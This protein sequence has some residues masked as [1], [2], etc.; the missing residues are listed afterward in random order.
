MKK[1]LIIDDDPGVRESYDQI[2]S[3]NPISDIM[4]RGRDLFAEEAQIPGAMSEPQY[5]ITLADCGEVGVGAVTEAVKSQS[6]YAAA[7]I[8][9]MM[10]GIDGAE[11]ARQ[12][13]HIDPAIKIVIV[14]AY[15]DYTPDDIVRLVGR[16]DIFYLRKPFNP[17][18]IRQF[19][20]ALTNQWQLEREKNRLSAE[21][22]RAHEYE[23]NTAARIQQTLLLGQPP[24]DI[25]GIQLHQKTIPSQKVDGDFIDFIRPGDPVLDIVVG[26]V[27]GKGIPAALVGAALKSQLLRALNKLSKSGDS[28]EIP[29]PESIVSEVQA[30]MI[31][32]LE[33]LETF[34]TLCYARFDLTRSLIQY[35]DCGHTRTIHFQKETNTCRLLEGVNMPLG[36]PEKEAFSQISVPF[37]PGDLF[38]FYSDGLTEAKNKQ[39]ELYGEKRLVDFVQQ[40]AAAD[41]TD[42]I[43]KIWQNVVGFR[44]SDIFND[45]FT[46]IAV[47]IMEPA[48]SV[49]ANSPEGQ[50]EIKSDLNELARV[51]KFVR[52]FCSRLPEELL[53]RSRIDL[54]ELAVNEAVVNIIK[55]AYRNAPDNPVRI[56]AQ[57]SPDQLVFRLY[58]WG[59]RFDP[60]AV[61]PPAFDGS[62]DHGF[63]IY[64]I[65]Q[66]VDEVTYSREENGRNCAT[67]T[68]HL[69]GGN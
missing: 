42:L 6:P 31:Q 16:E 18:E 8:D 65:K 19:A 41:L 17:A 14:T 3:S 10:P 24:Q 26:D 67:L 40:H 5:S 38:F 12:I 68:I 13:W 56:E 37:R 69:R 11:T 25:Q 61:P 50:L 23:I 63:G 46:C 29:E 60:T 48:E 44:Q 43:Q 15:S 21:L 45:D 58:D 33:N 28:R 4:S 1:I 55:H 47:R 22:A 7:F 35:V 39:A 54:I 59:R 36:F 30:G 49:P 32:D 53:D 64:I 57:L 34:V 66:A 27:M 51:R 62:R 20:R 2:L 52:D 9:M